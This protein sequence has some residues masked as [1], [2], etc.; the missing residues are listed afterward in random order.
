VATLIYDAVRKKKK[1]YAENYLVFVGAFIFIA[2][3]IIDVQVH[4]SGGRSLPLGLAETGM[5]VFI[6]LNMI[7]LTLQF[8]RTE[9]E[10]DEARRSERETQEKN[11][12]LD[13]MS[14]LKSDF[15]ANI[16]HEMRTPLTVMAS[17]AGLTAMQIRQ[18]ALNEK[19]LDNLSIIQREA[20]RLA[21]LVEQLKEVSLEKER[22][23]A[24]TDTD[25]RTL[26]RDAADFCEPICRKNK[27]RI[28]VSTGPI[29]L[30]VNTDSIFQTLVNLIV[31]ASRHTKEG[32]IQL[33]AEEMDDFVTVTVRD[34]GEGIPPERLANLFERGVSADN[35]TGLGLP[36]CKEIIEELPALMTELKI[37]KLADII[38]AAV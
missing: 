24:L 17:Y 29:A 3:S 23:L 16:S 19:S 9:T 38:G 4:R 27:N 12:L 14:R 8:S 6:F 1:R 5:L 15:L 37:E 34:D 10:L 30:R 25:A 32:I 2:L 20:K 26:L 21:G 36:I 13:E 33:S 18:G 22:Q 31:N 28:M 35:S 7:A 11:R